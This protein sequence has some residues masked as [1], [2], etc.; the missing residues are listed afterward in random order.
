[1]QNNE[2]PFIV[3]GVSDSIAS[4]GAL[5]WAADEAQRR[6]TRL[7]VVR[8]WEPAYVA[9][10]A[11]HHEDAGHERHAVTCELANTLYAVFGAKLPP[12]VFTEVVEGTP[13]RVLA[14]ESAGADMLVLGSTSM[15]AAAGRSIGPVIRSCLSRAHCPVVVIGPEGTL[16]NG[17]VTRT[18][19]QIGGQH[20]P[21]TSTV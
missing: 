9:S 10:Y 15:P 12:H 14:D 13:E 11:P 17:R 3:V 5:R 1:M 19:V 18:A 7:Q 20:S 21:V 4:R 16:G 8:A 2:K 6:N